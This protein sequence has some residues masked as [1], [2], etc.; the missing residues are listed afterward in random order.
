M[1][2]T[3]YKKGLDG[4]VDVV[5]CVRRSSTSSSSHS[6]VCSHTR[7][8]PHT[9][10]RTHSP[11]THSTRTNAYLHSPPPPPLHTTAMSASSS[12]APLAPAPSSRAERDRLRDYYGLASAAASSSSRH[13]IQPAAPIDDPAQKYR[14][15]VKREKIAGLLKAQSNLLTGEQGGRLD[16]AARLAIT[17]SPCLASPRS[18]H[19]RDPGAGRR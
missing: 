17:S 4:E 7:A 13:P 9:H 14:D 16:S 11:L 12:A 3:K 6:H 18:S 15:L 2:G 10:T 5:A 19:H 8:L 1:E